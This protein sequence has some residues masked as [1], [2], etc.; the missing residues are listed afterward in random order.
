M[1]SPQPGGAVVHGNN[2]LG[3]AT[4]PEPS[5]AAG[6]QRAADLIVERV[7]AAPGEIT[8]IAVGPLT[9]LAIATRLEPRIVQNVH[10]LVVMGGAVTVPGNGAVTR[11]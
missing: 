4:L 3:R 10:Q 11:V 5:R 2:G 1:R 6:S 8:L 9:N 7:M